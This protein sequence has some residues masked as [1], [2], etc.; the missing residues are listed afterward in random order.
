MAYTFSRDTVVYCPR[1]KL[2]FCLVLIGSDLS[3]VFVGFVGS[4]SIETLGK[5]YKPFS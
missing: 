1:I 5:A 2:S 3:D 4:D